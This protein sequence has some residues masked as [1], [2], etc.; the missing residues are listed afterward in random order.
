MAKTRRDKQRHE[1]R[2]TAAQRRAEKHTGGFG[3]T[4]FKVPDG[5]K[6]FQPKAGTYTL[7]IVPFKVGKRKFNPEISFADEGHL[8]YEQTYFTHFKVGPAEK[9][10]V[11][12][13]RTFDKKCYVCEE[14]SRLDRKGASKE[15]IKALYAKERQVFLVYDHEDKKKGLQ[16]WDVSYHNFGKLLDTRIR[17]A[18]ESRLATF[19]DP[20]TKG[21][22]LEILLEEE[23]MGTNKYIEAKSIDF[24][25]REDAIPDKILKAAPCLGDL[26]IM[27]NYEKIKEAFEGDEE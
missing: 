22:T 20:S 26:I 27:P 25:P 16:V 1:E 7:D 12:A 17:S 24:L 10:Y 14:R 6:L 23:T 21:K 19:D 18:K 15:T 3:P 9:S 11:C 8:Y 5:M 2:K 4:G 13:S